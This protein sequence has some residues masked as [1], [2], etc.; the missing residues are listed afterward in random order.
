MIQKPCLQAVKVNTNSAGE[1][2]FLHSK[3]SV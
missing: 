3:I 2:L 1:N